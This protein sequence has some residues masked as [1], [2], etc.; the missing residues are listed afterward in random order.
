MQFKTFLENMKS[1][2]SSA[3]FMSLVSSETKTRL[4]YYNEGKL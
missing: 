4:G 2:H 3:H 1:E